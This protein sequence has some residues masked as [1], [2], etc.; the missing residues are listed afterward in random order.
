MSNETFRV[1]LVSEAADYVSISQILHRDYSLRELIA[2]MLP[3][4]GRDAA[5]ISQL[6]RVGGFSN[7]EYKFRWEGREVGVRQVEHELE[8]FPRAEP[9]R[10]FN[11]GAC[12]LIRFVREV[13]V[14][15]LPREAAEKKGLLGNLFGSLLSS[16]SFF[17]GLLKLAGGG[18]G[19]RYADYSFADQADVYVLELGLDTVEKFR[20]LLPL[21]KPK[22]AGERIVYLRP[23][24]IELLTRR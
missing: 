14:L 10:P 3:V 12:V 6:L 5:R 8:S 11:A 24:K 15:A 21:M 17:D 19:L 16:E 1:K 4:V 9:Q 13:E 20:A 18:G 2:A 22:S 23:E 7:G